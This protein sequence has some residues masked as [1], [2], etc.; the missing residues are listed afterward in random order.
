MSFSSINSLDVSGCRDV[1]VPVDESNE[2]V[3]ER[4]RE[5][6]KNGEYTI[7]KLIAPKKIIKTTL[8]GNHIENEEVEINGRKMD[9]TY[10]RM[11][12]L[13]KNEKLMR[14]RSDEVFDNMGRESI[15]EN[16]QKLNEVQSSG[17]NLERNYLRNRLKSLKMTGHLMCWHDGS[18]ISGHGYI[19]ITISVMFDVG[20]ILPEIWRKCLRPINC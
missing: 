11:K 17:L 7:G 8:C 18:P 10:I 2:K 12:L 14:K 15:I 1:T 13:E 5:K 3:T 9:I 19:V 6:I 20:R 16:L 4:L